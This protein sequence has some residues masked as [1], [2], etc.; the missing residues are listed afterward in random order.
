MSN[1][2]N[3]P[4]KY[5]VSL[6]AML[7]RLR[8]D[9]QALEEQTRV[10]TGGDVGGNLSSVPMHLGDLGTETYMQELNSTL[11]ETESHLRDEVLAALDRMDRGQYGNCEDCSR[12]IKEARLA[13]VPYTRY[14]AACAER[15]ENDQVEFNSG[16]VAETGIESIN[17]PDAEES[18]PAN[19]EDNENEILFSDLPSQS[20]DKHP[21][22]HA[23]GTPGGGSAVGGLG[24]TNIGGGDPD[25]VDMEDAMGSSNFDVELSTD[26]DEVT[27][28]SGP[29][30]GAVGGTPAGKRVVGGKRRTR[31]QK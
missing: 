17:V 14:C 9:T 28:Y 27:A 19:M 22:T 20:H 10:S 21:D 8:G 13:V 3:Q 25:D 7:D 15:M 26:E 30:G 18:E 6:R 29:S 31:P 5:R 12:K 1:N 2:S 4:G 16:R 24:G 23:A 11:L